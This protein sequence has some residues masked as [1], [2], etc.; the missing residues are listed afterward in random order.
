MDLWALFIEKILVRIPVVMSTQSYFNNALKIFEE[1]SSLAYFVILELMIILFPW[2]Y[3]RK[4]KAAPRALNI[5]AG[6]AKLV[7]TAIE[8]RPYLNKKGTPKKLALS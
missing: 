8:F 6:W 7:A 4:T 1:V 3:V 5:A 2:K